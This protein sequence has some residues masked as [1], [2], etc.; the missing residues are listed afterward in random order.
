MTAYKH[1]KRGETGKK[2]GGRTSWEV[3][4]EGLERGGQSE[5]YVRKEIRRVREMEESK[6]WD[7]QRGESSGKTNQR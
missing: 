5:R 4:M 1:E 3:G 7:V 6:R 2:Q